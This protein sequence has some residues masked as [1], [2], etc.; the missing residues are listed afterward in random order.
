MFF[1][2]QRREYKYDN[3]GIDDSGGYN[4]GGKGTPMN[5]GINL[6]NGGCSDPSGKGSMQYNFG[7]WQRILWQ[8]L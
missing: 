5:G 7:L 3:N 4:Y 1:V 2:E 8:G 6:A